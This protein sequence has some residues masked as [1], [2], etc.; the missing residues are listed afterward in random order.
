MTTEIFSG[1]SWVLPLRDLNLRNRG[2]QGFGHYEG[3][4]ASWASSNLSIVLALA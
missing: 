3:R 1:K 4:R 2:E